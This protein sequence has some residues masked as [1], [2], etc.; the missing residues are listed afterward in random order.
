GSRS[1]PT[2]GSAPRTAA[3]SAALPVPQA[4]S[5]TASPRRRS[6]A[7]ATTSATGA[8]RSAIRAYAPRPQVVVTALGDDGRL[9]RGTEAGGRGA[10]RAPQPQRRE[11]RA[12]RRRAVER[13]EVDAGR[14]VGEEVGALHRRVGDA[15]VRDR[16]RVVLASVELAQ[17]VLGH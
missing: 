1:T 2:T 7:S 15:E 8:R 12:R 16:A 17:H 9:A 5:R 6:A 11:D 4:T 3:A 10:P 13:A 14:A